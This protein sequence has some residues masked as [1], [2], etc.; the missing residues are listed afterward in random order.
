MQKRLLDNI[1]W[2][3]SFQKLH[4]WVAGEI[5]VG[6]KSECLSPLCKVHPPCGQTKKLAKYTSKTHAESL[7]PYM[8]DNP[9]LAVS[10]L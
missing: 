6:P 8:L 5:I 3:L 2:G 4:S 1:G 7:N 9:N 10:G